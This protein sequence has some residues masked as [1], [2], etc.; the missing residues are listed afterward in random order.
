MIRILKLT[1]LFFSF[2]YSINITA[3]NDEPETT[4]EEIFTVVEK[5]PQFIG[6]MEEFYMFLLI[7]IKYPDEARES[8]VLGRVL[9]KFVIEKDGSITN[10]NIAE[11]IGSGCDKEAI[12]VI[13][14]MPKW[15]PGEQRGKKIR[16]QYTLP[17]SFRYDFP[18]AKT[19][20]KWK[21]RYSTWKEMTPGLVLCRNVTFLVNDFGGAY[22]IKMNGCDYGG[23]KMLLSEPGFFKPKKR[24]GKQIRVKID[25]NSMN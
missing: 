1:L 8:G 15:T 2:C 21:K 6:G 3:Q 9:V 16:V 14:K 4:V 25:L 24:K 22:D 13:E 18:K 5:M 23:L 11:G 12:R 20:K 19:T 10:V 17:I 7:N